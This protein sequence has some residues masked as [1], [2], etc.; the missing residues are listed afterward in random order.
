[1]R[2]GRRPEEGHE[3]DEAR[4]RRRGRSSRSE[5]RTTSKRARPRARRPR[6]PGAARAGGARLQEAEGLGL[7]RHDLPAGRGGDQRDEGQARMA[8]EQEQAVPAERG[9]RPDPRSHLGQQRSEAGREGQDQRVAQEREAVR[10]KPR[11]AGARHRDQGKQVQGHVAG[12]EERRGGVRVGGSAHTGS[13]RGRP[14]SCS[15]S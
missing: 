14:I 12:E 4:D 8:S 13:S 5:A 6:G 2:P 9:R 3:T 1:V 15:R 10:W 11:D 7:F